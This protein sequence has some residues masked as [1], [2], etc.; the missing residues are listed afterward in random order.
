MSWV[1]K[2]KR[3]D[4]RAEFFSLLADFQRWVLHIFFSYMY[5]LLWQLKG[6]EVGKNLS[7]NGSML[8]RRFKHSKIVIGDNC[9]F[10]S[11]NAFNTRGISPC[12]IGTYTD[13]AKIEI[14]NNT[15]MS[16]VTINCREYIKIG[17]QVMLG[18]NVR[19]GDNDDHDDILNTTQAPIV[20]GD[21]VFVG[22]N[23]V[24]LKGVTIGEH[25]IIGAGSIVTK[26]IPAFCVAAGN[27]C[28]II[29]RIS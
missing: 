1:S 26:D 29:K 14:G 23:S 12:I 8:M 11:H 22:M 15:G 20:I 24:I 21:S 2:I 7:V 17:N 3:A 27:P 18:A 4:Y 16:G 10:N 28:K 13:Y 6:I 9:T 25:S 19:I 5:R